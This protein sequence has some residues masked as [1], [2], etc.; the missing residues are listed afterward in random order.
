[1]ELNVLDILAKEHRKWVGMVRS[2][3]GGVESED[4]V[5][6]M[7]IKIYDWKGKY[8]KVLMYNE[9]EVNQYFIFLTLRHLFL[10]VK[11]KEKRKREALNKYKKEVSSQIELHF[12]QLEMIQKEIETWHRY[13]RLIY[14]LIFQLGKS[15]L[16]VSKESGI[17]YYSIYRTVKKIKN[18]N[19]DYKTR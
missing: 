13:D 1:M 2:F 17:N 3:G 8:D 19:Y 6:D 11:R 5:Q 12:D 7:Y 4:I 14:I 10:D 18:L 15:M 9:K 16:Q